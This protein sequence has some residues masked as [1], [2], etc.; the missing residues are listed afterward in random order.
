MVGNT[1]VGVTLMYLKVG[2]IEEMKLK[3]EK[4]VFL[5]GEVIEK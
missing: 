1:K 3:W 5:L 4:K 2:T